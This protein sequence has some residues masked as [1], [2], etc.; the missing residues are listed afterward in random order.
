MTGR[1]ETLLS[2]FVGV[3]APATLF[4]L[5]WWS[6]AALSIYGPAPVSERAI[7]IAALS[8]LVIGVGADIW[9]LRRWARRLYQAPAALVNLLYVVWSVM[10]LGL[11]MGV[12]VGVLVVGIGVGLY[13]GRR[14]RYAGRDEPAARAS[15][16]RTAAFTA[17]VVAV[18]SL[19]VGWLALGERFT[20][21][22]LLSMVGMKALFGNVFA[23]AALVLVGCTALAVLQHVLTR[24]AA[25]TAYGWGLPPR[26]PSAPESS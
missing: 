2:V 11:C 5:S 17:A 10:A 21:R 14:D 19:G 4:V 20:M 15:A 12:P 6:A 3:A 8:G 18:E 23:E 16:R 25:L 13:Q 9:L 26:N 7:A 24:R 22:R 1:E